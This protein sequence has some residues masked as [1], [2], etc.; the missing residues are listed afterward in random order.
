MAR[1]KM[2]TQRQKRKPPAVQRQQPAPEARAG[3][4]PA[5][6]AADLMAPPSAELGAADRA[7][8][9]PTLQQSVGNTRLNRMLDPAPQE[10][11]S[12]AARATVVQR[13]PDHGPAPAAAPAPAA[14]PLQSVLDQIVSASVADTL[15]RFQDIPIEVTEW[16]PLPAGQIGPPT[17]VT[18]TVHV[19][20][21]YFINTATARAHYADERRAANFRAIVR[22]LRRRGAVSTIRGSGGGELSSGQAVEV[23]KGTPEDIKLFIEEA[24]SQGAVRRYAIAQGAIGGGQWLT[25]LAVESLQAL[26][27]RWIYHVGVGVDCSGF[28]LQAAIRAREAERAAIELFNRVGSAFGL[29]PMPLPPERSRAI[30]NAASFRRGPRVPT[31]ADLRPGDAWIVTGGGHIRIVSA[32]REVTL[33]DGTVTIEFDTAESAGGSTQPEPGPVART[34]RTR[35]RERFH[36]IKPMD[37]G[38]KSRGGTFHRIP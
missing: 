36:E 24:I 14:D 32:V 28:V 9:M 1:D 23:G 15:R 34:W 18:K 19:A 5:A 4:L 20:A 7:R 16:I 17:P 22:E 27:Q 25:D 13:Q 29:P 6:R 31:P 12:S 21:G 33:E 3:P 38:A 35:S 10:Q 26:L 8:T 30:R 11:P 2:L 37:P